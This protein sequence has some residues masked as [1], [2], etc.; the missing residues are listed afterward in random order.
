MLT[1][2]NILEGTHANTAPVAEII[3]ISDNGI[4]FIAKYVI[5]LVT[6]PSIERPTR[7]KRLPFGKI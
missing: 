7:I 4:C 6:D 3:S 1:C 2:R 5:I